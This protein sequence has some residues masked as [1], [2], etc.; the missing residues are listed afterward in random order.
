M[1]PRDSQQHQPLLSHRPRQIG[2][3]RFIALHDEATLNRLY[4]A[5]RLGIAFLWLWTAFVSWFAWPHADS[6]D[7]LRRAGIGNYTWLVFVGACL[8]DL[9]MGIA[10][11]VHAR[12]WLW[13][14]QCALVAAYSIVIGV[15]LPEFLAHPFGAL[16]KNIPVLLCLVFLAL[17]DA[18]NASPRRQF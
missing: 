16:T 13:W 12:P 15:Q 3:E 11:L 17:A 14:L 10:C 9:A 4:W 5:I 2:R 7:L 8:A 6:L 1:T 18:R